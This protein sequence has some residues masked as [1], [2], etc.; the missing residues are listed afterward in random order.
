M[1]IDMAKL[2]RY[3]EPAN[4]QDL[5]EYMEDKGELLVDHARAIYLAERVLEEHNTYLDSFVVTR[6]ANTV[7][8]T[9]TDGQVAW[10]VEFGAHAGGKTYVLGYAPLRRAVDI[11]SATD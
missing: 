5:F 10:W 4:N 6:T 11:L 3:V 8:V 1:A 7:Q 2:R 9:N